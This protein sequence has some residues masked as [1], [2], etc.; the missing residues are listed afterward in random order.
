MMK[1]TEKI[2]VN[3][4]KFL[5]SDEY[6]EAVIDECR[7]EMENDEDLEEIQIWDKEEDLGMLQIFTRSDVE[8]KE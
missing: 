8:K 1:K 6:K 5:K 2:K 3:G 7:I 4:E